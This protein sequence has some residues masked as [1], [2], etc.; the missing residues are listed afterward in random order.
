MKMGHGYGRSP[1]NKRRHAMKNVFLFIF[2]LASF[3]VVADP[4]CAQWKPTSSPPGGY[5]ICFASSGSKIYIGTEG[6]GVY[7]STDDGSSWVQINHGLNSLN[8]RALAAMGTDIFSAVWNSAGGSTVYRSTDEGANWTKAGNGLP[9]DPRFVYQIDCLAVLSNAVG[10][11]NLY[12]GAIDGGVYVST[13]HGA[14]WIPDTAGLR[15]MFVVSMTTSD[16][17]LYAGTYT[18]IY[19]STSNA[20]SWT[21]THNSDFHYLSVR[22]VVAR[23]SLVLASGLTQGTPG[24][25]GFPSVNG[26]FRSTNFG[27]SWTEAYEDSGRDAYN[28]RYG[29]IAP[30]AFLGSKVFAGTSKGNILSSSDRGLHWSLGCTLPGGNE[31]RSLF[32]KDSSI[33]AGTYGLGVFCSE[34]SGA[35]WSSKGTGL[36]NTK[37]QSIAILDNSIFAGTSAVGIYRSTDSGKSWSLVNN[38][39]TNLN[40][41]ALAVASTGLFAG[42]YGGGIFRT[43]DDGENWKLVSSGLNAFSITPALAAIDSNLFAGTLGPGVYLSTDNGAGW[44]SVSTGLPNDLITVLA[45]SKPNLF[46]G[47]SSEGVYLSTDNGTHWNDAS[48][49]L[50]DRHIVALAISGTDVYATTMYG[51]LFVSTNNGSSWS[52]VDSNGMNAS[53]LSLAVDSKNLYAGTTSSGVL[54]RPVSEITSVGSGSSLLPNAFSLNQ[55]YPNPFNPSTTI[56]FSIAERS[57]VRV[58]IFNLLGQQVAELANEEMGAGNFERVWNANIASGMYFYR[59]EAVSV[60]NPGK[61]F[62]DV[63]KMVLVR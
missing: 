34:D 10:D 43:T 1:F 29:I 27:D 12:A 32:V 55:N 11:S 41:S 31:V 2:V 61:R 17:N 40:V 44:N 37:I 18:G 63:K 38:G 7:F 58:T 60:S 50:T 6:G 59:L 35:T 9:N 13:D 3:F 5:V 33:F 16:T 21:P 39:L 53:V 23:D 28:T 48:I 57:R 46:A 25:G 30:M 54:Y 15:N 47:T 42:F 20:A 49:G 14:N 22:S 52:K 56:R 4:L 8:V 62:V 45:A 51:S 36:S 26:I 24:V 19:R